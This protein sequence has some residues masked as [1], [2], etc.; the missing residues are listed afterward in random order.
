MKKPSQSRIASELSKS[1]DTKLKYYALAAS[2][3]GAGLLATSPAE[4]KVIYT[5]A[6]EAIPYNEAPVAIDLNHDGI[7]DFTLSGIQ[8]VGGR[9][10][11]TFV[12]V[13]PSGP[14][15]RVWGLIEKSGAN[16]ASTLAAADLPRG[17]QVGPKGRFANDGA[18]LLAARYISEGTIGSTQGA[19]G[20]WANHGKGAVNRFLAFKFTINN[21]IHYGWARL[22]VVMDGYPRATLT[23]YAYETIANKPIITGAP[24]GADVS[25]TEPQPATLGHL[26]AG[27][28]AI[29]AWR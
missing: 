18:E 14:D 16:S 25:T 23:G 7:N 4:A 5:P 6:N 19:F 27:A 28:P 9:F 17:V 26:A 3:A 11:Q 22:N 15:N 13:A 12:Q 21:Q 24:G 10:Y 2:A 20:L 1:L 8:S 29:Q